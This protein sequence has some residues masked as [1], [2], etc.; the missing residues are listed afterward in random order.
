MGLSASSLAVDDARRW[1]AAPD[2]GA[3]VVFTGMVRD[4]ADGRT[5]VTGL[6][7]EAYEEHAVTRIQAV[8]DEARGRW[9]AA[10]RIVIWHRVGALAVGDDAVV[11]A[12]SSAHR[13]EA[14]AVAS[15]CID[16][17]KATAPI[18]KQERWAG[19]TEWGTDATPLADIAEAVRVERA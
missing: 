13:A 16:T 11:V 14:F 17:V 6:T 8:V 19:G 7:Y 10:R 18:W 4:H 12:V 1:V 3:V 2:C 5:G 15:F 9:P